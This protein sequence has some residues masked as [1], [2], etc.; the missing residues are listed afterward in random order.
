MLLRL[1]GGRST[2]ILNIQFKSLE[3][4][5]LLP[6]LAGLRDE[7]TEKRVRICGP[8]NPSAVPAQ[9]KRTF[10]ST[11]SPAPRGKEEESLCLALPRN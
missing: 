4:L 9:I 6:L 10:A 7:R 3:K 11:R 2:G 8:S 1:V 5:K